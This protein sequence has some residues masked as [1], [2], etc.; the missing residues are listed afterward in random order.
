MSSHSAVLRCPVEVWGQILVAVTY[1]CRTGPKRGPLTCTTGRDG[2]RNDFYGYSEAYQPHTDAW[3]AWFED[4]RFKLDP[5]SL[6]IA[7]SLDWSHR[8]VCRSWNRLLLPMLF[9]T[10]RIHRDYTDLVDIF[11]I[12]GTRLGTHA[13]GYLVRRLL[14]NIRYLEDW[15]I[16]E[17]DEETAARLMDNLFNL[18][19]QLQEIRYINDVVLP[20]TDWA[21]RPYSGLKRLAMG[22]CTSINPM[23]MLDLCASL[24]CLELLDLSWYESTTALS[25]ERT[26]DAFRWRLAS[27]T[28]LALYAMSM[29]SPWIQCL[30]AC[31]FPR[32]K[33]LY[34]ACSPMDIL[35]DAEPLFE[36]HGEKLKS[37][38]FAHQSVPMDDETELTFLRLCPNLEEY[39]TCLPFY[40]SNTVFPTLR[41]LK[42]LAASGFENEVSAEDMAL[43]AIGNGELTTAQPEFFAKL[44]PF[45]T[46]SLAIIK[47]LD[48]G[49]DNARESV[50]LRTVSAVF[51]ICRA[52]GI[53]LLDGLEHDITNLQNANR[54]HAY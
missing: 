8:L 50:S 37:I 47:G 7:N 18:C 19:P 31:D 29:D 26:S 32:L 43:I 16:K 54:H 27:L 30:T 5:S 9:E 20:S 12:F 1:A 45:N 33:H 34:L 25:P 17:P 6:G 53:R 36:V 21:T 40:P 10:I 24:P 52:R 39:T 49:E 22:Q 13:Y 23:T 4:V 48:L 46:P 11:D 44:N 2:R 15:N 51:E 3:S 41:K 28:H 35:L 42:V 14:V 38:V